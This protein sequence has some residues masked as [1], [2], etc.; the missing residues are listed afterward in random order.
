MFNR[1]YIDSFRVHFQASYISLSE[2][3]WTRKVPSN[4]SWKYGKACSF[5][6]HKR[7]TSNSMEFLRMES[8]RLGR[9]WVFVWDNDQKNEPKQ[10][11]KNQRFPKDFFGDIWWDDE[12]NFRPTPG[13]NRC[14]KGVDRLTLHGTNIGVSKNRGTPKWMVYNGKP[15]FLMDDLGGNTPILGNTHIA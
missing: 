10:I 13:G 5:L 12:T 11:S 8:G 3:L 15:Y 6:A 2:C 9:C 4:H 7:S 1:K 14:N